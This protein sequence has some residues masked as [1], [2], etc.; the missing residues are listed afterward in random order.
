MPAK[1]STY[2]ALLPILMVN[3]I[4]TM[5]FSIVLPFMVIIVLKLGGSAL[6]YGALGAT[7]SFFQLIGAP[8]LGG[9][10]DRF[11][12]R[13]ILLLSQLGTFIGWL[14]F[15]T[16]MILPNHFIHL[17]LAG[18]YLISIPLLFIFA[19][20]SLDGITGGNISVA[21]A[22]LADITEKADRKKNFG[23]MSAV[24]NMGLIC[25]PLLAGALGATA[26]GN[27]LPVI[28]AAFI[29]LVAIAVIYYRLQ[30]RSAVPVTPPS[31]PQHANKL[32]SQQ[33]KDCYK[34]AGAEKKNY[35]SAL[36][37]PY[38]GYFMVLYF[39]IFLSFNF[40]YVAFPVYV[41]ADLHWTV[42]QIGL[43]FS[44]L[45]GLLVLVQGPLL[46]FI[47][48]KLSSAILVIAG[49]VFL[50]CGFILFMYPGNVMIYAGAVFFA[51]GNGMMWPSFLALLSD[52]GDEHTQGA[53]QGFASSA[54]SM[55]SIIGLVTGALLYHSLG[56]RLFLVAG[57]FMLVI[58]AVATGL[59][60][61]E[62]A[63]T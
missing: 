9:W 21:N 41:A 12:R 40:F 24:A 31:V 11:G 25:G 54:G 14:V 44:V 3:F 36:K 13:K 42:L 63:L 38:V 20:R 53:I 4:G 50:S 26:L 22:Y 15:L 47:S 33:H 19:G 18:G 29:S 57:L 23:K 56:A 1:P 62:K 51:L 55:A 32:L 27:L 16:G 6:V 58:G 52:T 10:S 45:S 61:V 34:I 39:L 43:F 48:K 46:S 5:G 8:V 7:Y 37:L 59:I 30:D 28:A 60:K 2:P 17:K 35:L 49:S